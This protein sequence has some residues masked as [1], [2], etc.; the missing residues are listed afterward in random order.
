M[1]D[2]TPKQELALPVVA[3]LMADDSRWDETGLLP[4]CLATS[5]LRIEVPA[6]GYTP[7]PNELFYLNIFWDEKLLDG[8]VMDG[9]GATLPANDL[10]FD[11][12]VAQLTQG[13]HEL[14]YVVVNSDATPT[15]R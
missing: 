3:D 14:H 2:S 10:I 15:I 12:P 1:T 4:A 7:K 13:A 9:G 6:W 11:I 5:P 8:R